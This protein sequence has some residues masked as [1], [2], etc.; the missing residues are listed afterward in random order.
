MEAL[1]QQL[2]H[3][4]CPK[5]ICLC[6]MTIIELQKH[7]EQISSVSLRNLLCFKG[8]QYLHFHK[9]LPKVHWTCDCCLGP[10]ITLRTRN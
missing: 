5:L 7:L 4:G 10:H 9:Y 1:S 3:E 2:I 8:T 6:M